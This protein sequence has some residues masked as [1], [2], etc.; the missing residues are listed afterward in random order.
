MDHDYLSTEIARLEEEISH[1]QVLINDPELGDLA[2]E[3][4]T[5]LQK[6]IDSLKQATAVSA[7]SS[8]TKSADPYT[9]SPAIVEIRSAA[10]G[11]EAQLFGED[12]ARMYVR[13]ANNHGFS[14]EQL[15]DNVYRFSRPKK[16]LWN[17]G[18]FQTFRVEAGVHR[19]QRVPST[20]SAGRIH[21]STATVAVLPEIPPALITIN[22]NDLEWEFARSGGP[23]GQNVNKVSTAVRLHHKPSD[24]NIFVR[25]ER[26]QSR[27]K[28]IAL[29]LL[30]SKLWQIEEDKRQ[31]SLGE[32]RGAIG[33]GMR[34]EKIKTYNFPQ[35][36]LT[37]HRLDKSWHNLK[38]AIEGELEEILIYTIENLQ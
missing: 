7:D 31:E 32:Q 18:A 20:E 14:V 27:N 35:N 2:K 29:S 9:N 16:D 12:L 25:E 24:I 8:D 15:D 21:T 19:V 30:R 17:F 26:Y 36:R 23:G 1:H 37:D 22:E 4:I 3:E 33:R 6:Q 11:E 34:A 13:F 10:G 5:K 38:S 28:E